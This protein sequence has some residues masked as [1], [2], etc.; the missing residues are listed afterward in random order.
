MKKILFVTNMEQTADLLKDSLQKAQMQAGTE[1]NGEVCYLQ[2][3]SVWDKSWENIFLGCE[4]VIFPWMGTGLNTKFLSE[5]SSYLQYHQIKHLYLMSGNPGDVLHTVFTE[6][7]ITTI[8]QYYTYGGLQNWCNLWL[9][10]VR[11][12]LPKKSDIELPMQLPWD[13]I[14]HPRAQKIYT[15]LAEYK[16]EFFN[17]TQPVIAVVFYRN[18]WLWNNIVFA[19]NMISEIE[20]QGCNPLCFFSTSAP[21]EDNSCT[22]FKGALQK[23]LIDEGKAAADVFINTIK[24]SLFSIRAC[25]LDDLK[26]LN[27]SV[28]QAYTLYRTYQEWYE[29]LMV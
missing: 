20:K 24:F 23:Y 28:L 27:I 16:K 25:A 5:S 18:D 15:E 8:K 14:Y 13:G 17:N 29:I 3:D 7:E 9:W 10:L 4:T 21:D 19:D 22:G 12:T 2:S 1:I 6:M 26:T 11:E